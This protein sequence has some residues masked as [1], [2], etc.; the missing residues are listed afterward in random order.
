MKRSNSIIVACPTPMFKEICSLVKSLDD[1]AAINTQQ[2]K[3]VSIK[4]VD[5]ML[6][7]Q[8]IAAMQGRTTNQG[9]RTGPGTFGGPGGGFGGGGI[10]GFAVSA[11]LRRPRAAVEEVAASAAQVAAS[12]SAASAAAV[13]AVAVS[14][15]SAAS[16]GGMASAAAGLALAAV[17]WAAVAWAV[18]AAATGPEVPAALPR[19]VHAAS[20][21]PDRDWIFSHNGSRMTLASQS[22]T[23]HDKTTH[24]VMH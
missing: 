1:A 8:A 23:I 9:N 2:V 16:C 20:W 14:A 10:G 15:A 19:E 3:I 6:V 11:G 24:Q 17:A 13:S 7:A 18:A 12:A 4:G 22:S 21:S 5:P